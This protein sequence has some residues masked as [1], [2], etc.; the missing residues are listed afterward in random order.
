VRSSCGA[1]SSYPA[2]HHRAV[3]RSMPSTA[4][5]ARR[6]DLP[7]FLAPTQMLRLLSVS[8]VSSH[9]APMRSLVKVLAIPFLRDNKTGEATLAS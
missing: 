2:P 3:S 5:P 7:E 8:F 1:S 6:S 4:R 9:G